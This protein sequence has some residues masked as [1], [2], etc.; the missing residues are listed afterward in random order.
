MRKF[1]F[2]LIVLPILLFAT[3]TNLTRYLID[4]EY[5][6]EIWG[7]ESGV[8]ISAGAGIDSLIVNLIE[9]AHFNFHTSHIYGSDSVDAYYKEAMTVADLDSISWIHYDTLTTEVESLK[10]FDFKG[11]GRYLRVMYVIYT[12]AAEKFHWRVGLWKH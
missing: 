5:D 1:F 10:A 9:I 7:D 6:F 8:S 11:A 12:K 3:S 4:D 2:M